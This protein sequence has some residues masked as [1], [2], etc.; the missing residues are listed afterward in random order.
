MAAETIWPT[1]LLSSFLKRI[2][3]PGQRKYFRN[4]TLTELPS[5]MGST[6]WYWCS[7]TIEQQ[8]M[9]CRNVGHLVICPWFHECPLHRMGNHELLNPGCCVVP[10]DVLPVWCAEASVPLQV[11]ECPNLSR[12]ISCGTCCSCS[13]CGTCTVLS[14]THT[15]GGSFVCVTDI[16]LSQGR[17]SSKLN[18]LL[19]LST[20]IID[21]KRSMTILAPSWG[22][23]CRSVHEKHQDRSKS[24]LQNW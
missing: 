15:Y 20:L 2:N 22:G 10:A 4:G 19:D 14:S 11:S 12:M 17:H 1:S 24:T 8:Q 18:L 9:F 7:S 16:L 6:R 3:V 21:Q 13:T 5:K 23:D